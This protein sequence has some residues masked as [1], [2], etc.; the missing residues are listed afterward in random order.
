[1][2][3]QELRTYVRAQLDVEEEELPNDMTD[4]Y[5]AE[6]YIRTMSMENRWP[7]FETSWEVGKPGTDSVLVLPTD[8]DAGGLF[9]VRVNG[10]R[11]VQVS[12]EQA[13]DSNAQ[14][15]GT[16]TPGWYSLWGR[17]MRL[18]PSPTADVTVY[19]RGYRMPSDWISQ[20]AGAEVD[21]DVRLH[22]LLAHYAIALAY[23]Q[24]ED[25]VLEDVYMKR[26]QAS[27]MAARNAICNPRHNRPLVFSGGMAV[28]GAGPQGGAQWASPPVGP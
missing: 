3:L 6:A 7:F 14:M 17:E 12:N 4:A 8:C 9:S 25:E 21:A 26:W 23:A 16:T 18:W 28:I 24:Q 1:V 2:N 20:G 27:F 11:L 5:L 15:A 22:R 13:E 10:A 19:L